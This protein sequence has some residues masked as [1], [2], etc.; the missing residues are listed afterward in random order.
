MISMNRRKIK[1]TDRIELPG[2]EK[3]KEIKEIEADR[4]KYLGI[5]EYDR[6]EEQE[7]KDKFKNE[8]F[9]GAKLILK[10]KPNGR[11]KIMAMNPWTMSILRYDAV[12]LKWNKNELQETGIKTRK[13]MTMNKGLHPRSDFARLYVSRKNGGTGLIG[14]ENSVKGEESGL[15]W[16]F[17]NNLEPLLAAVRT[18][19]YIKNEE[20]VDPK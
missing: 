10:S 11:N 12:I 1:S 7:M 18:S 16:C 8:Y 19:G 14:G 4:Y 9:R 6:V 3:I 2:A 20:T 15:G 5:S 13:V 17:K